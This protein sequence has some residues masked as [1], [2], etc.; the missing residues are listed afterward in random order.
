MVA[1]GSVTADGRSPRAG[2]RSK[3]LFFLAKKMGNA[4]SGSNLNEWILK[5]C[6]F[7]LGYRKCHEITYELALYK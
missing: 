2:V 7:D 3:V 6:G 5:Q 4:G 1:E